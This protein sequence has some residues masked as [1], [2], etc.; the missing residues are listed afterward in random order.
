MGTSRFL[1]EYLKTDWRFI[2][3]TASVFSL[4]LAFRT[5]RND[6]RT[7]HWLLSLPLSIF[8]FVLIWSTL[9]I[10]TYI[11]IVIAKITTILT[12]HIKGYFTI[13]RLYFEIPESVV[14]QN[15]SQRQSA[16]ARNARPVMQRR[17]QELPR[18]TVVLRTSLV[19]PR[20]RPGIPNKVSVQSHRNC[21]CAIHK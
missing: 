2:Q 15:S 5:S 11:F 20:H 16:V 3:W 1:A 18:R 6:F 13:Q 19:S 4:V 9:M 17:S 21:S 7:S 12:P 14:Y 8:N 10:I